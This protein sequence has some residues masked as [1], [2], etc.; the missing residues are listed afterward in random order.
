MNLITASFS[1][2]FSGTTG[3]IGSYVDR[4]GV[5]LS[6]VDKITSCALEVDVDS[7]LLSPPVEVLALLVE[8]NTV[9]DFSI[10]PSPLALVVSASLNFCSVTP[11]GLKS[12]ALKELDSIEFTMLFSSL[13]CKT[14][15]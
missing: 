6:L 5:E 4:V 13:T 10:A 2:L 1:L 3:P 15:Q 9:A 11:V 8:S 12:S 14:N 7:D